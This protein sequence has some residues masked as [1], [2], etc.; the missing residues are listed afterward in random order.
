LS[1]TDITLTSTAGNGSA[2]I[3]PPLGSPTAFTA[4]GA[5][6][7][8]TTPILGVYTPIAVGGSGGTG[9]AFNYANN[10]GGRAAQTTSSIT[11]PAAL[12]LDV[13][14]GNEGATGIGRRTRPL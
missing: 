8:Y 11:L 1:S 13:A 12:T 7:T 2:E 4:T 6:Q 5:V 10:P 14:V 3:I 9:E